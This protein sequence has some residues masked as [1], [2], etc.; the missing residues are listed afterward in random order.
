MG[1]PAHRLIARQPETGRRDDVITIFVVVGLA[2]VV[3]VVV[4]EVRTVTPG[5]NGSP[6]GRC[7]GAGVV[8][9]GRVTIS[10]GLVFTTGL[11]VC[12]AVVCRLGTGVLLGMIVTSAQP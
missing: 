7:V 11:G 1:F 12:C 10:V 6:P 2:V 9:G 3:V 5:M 8:R 4:E